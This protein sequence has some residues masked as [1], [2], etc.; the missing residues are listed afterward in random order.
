MEE[1]TD[2]YHIRIVNTEN[3][4]YKLFCEICRASYEPT[5]PISVVA[6]V[7]LVESFLEEHRHRQSRTKQ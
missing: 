5:L 7:A 3:G 6:F 2:S 1:E 4:G